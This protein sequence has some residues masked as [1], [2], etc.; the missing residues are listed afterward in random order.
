MTGSQASRPVALIT[1]AARGLG[2]G[3][4]REAASRGFSV[5]L[6]DRDDAALSKTAEALA[7]TGATVMALPVDVAIP[8]SIDRLAQDVGDRLGAVT[9]LVNNAGIELVGKIWELEAVEIERIVRINLLGAMQVVQAFVPAMI[10][11]SL[12]SR[13]VNVASLGGMG[14]MPLQTAYIVT[15]QAMLAYSEGLA[16]EL[17]QFAPHVHVSVVLPGAVNTPIF[18]AQDVGDLHNRAFRSA[19]KSMLTIEG[20]IPDEAA[21][22]IMAQVEAGRFWISSHPDQLA[23]LARTRGQRLASLAEPC[24]DEA[25]ERL[26]REIGIVPDNTG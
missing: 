19:M 3:L 26:M 9:L 21:R 17:Q 14:A 12:P 23:A 6:A 4:A 7:E 20:M 13:I 25:G 5:V 8:A 11:G 24:L 10:A 18:D 2:A 16:L 1:G 22:S 15:K